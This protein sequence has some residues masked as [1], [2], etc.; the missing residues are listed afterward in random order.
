MRYA[1]PT[2]TSGRKIVHKIYVVKTGVIEMAKF[3]PEQDLTNDQMVRAS[4]QALAILLHCAVSMTVT[5]GFQDRIAA[6][7]GIDPA[8]HWWQEGWDKAIKIMMTEGA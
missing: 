2:A 6:E 3:G 7:L 1:G 8:A 4:I 5:D